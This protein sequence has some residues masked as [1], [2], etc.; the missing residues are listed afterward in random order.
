MR[1]N[2]CTGARKHVRQLFR[3]SSSVEVMIALT[4]A[5]PYSIVIEKGCRRIL[6]V[7]DEYIAGR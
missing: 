4:Y 1:E 3:E 6:E 2:R 7:L 5:G